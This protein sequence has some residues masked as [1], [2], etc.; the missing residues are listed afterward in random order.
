MSDTKRTLDDIEDIMKVVMSS[1]DINLNEV[2]VKVR[3]EIAHLI[4]DIRYKVELLVSEPL[5]P[6]I[7]SGTFN[8]NLIN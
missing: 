3:S 7:D 6:K 8:K 4:N 2:S 5:A 1:T